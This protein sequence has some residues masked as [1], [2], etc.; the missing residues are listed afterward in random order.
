M[1]LSDD[2]SSRKSS[3]CHRFFG[4][5]KR[6]PRDVKRHCGMCRQHGVVVETR[7]HICQFKN[8]ECDKCKLVRKRRS[9]MSTQ[10]RLRRE[11][12][13]RFQRTTIAS[14]ADV[15][16]SNGVFEAEKRDDI[17]L[18][19]FCQKCKNHGVLMWKKVSVSVNS[20]D[21]SSSSS[22]EEYSSGSD[23]AVGPLPI[24][25][26]P[27]SFACNTEAIPLLPM[28][29]IPVL[30]SPMSTSGNLLMPFL[31]PAIPNTSFL[32]LSSLLYG[33]FVPNTS[34]DLLVSNFLS[35]LSPFEIQLL[36]ASSLH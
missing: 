18:C 4:Y 8:C 14:E 33:G 10:I 5:G 2:G 21:Y 17:S 15:V 16:P 24:S 36:L 30:K 20:S 22:S 9:I 23:S 3:E 6:I 26:M 35:A 31:P 7:G 32:P 12:D 11:Q 19:Y 34:N 29:D 13:K 1:S 27:V 25:A 28:P